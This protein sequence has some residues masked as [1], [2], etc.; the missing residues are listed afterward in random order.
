MLIAFTLSLSL[1]SARGPAPGVARDAPVRS[2]RDTAARTGADTT[3]YVT[4]RAR[5]D[6]RLDR[7]FADSLEYGFIVTRYREAAD[8]SRAQRLLGRFSSERGDSVR[9][10]RAEFLQRVQSG[11]SVAAVHGEGVVLYIHGFATSFRRAV[12]QGT[13][14]AHRTQ[15]SG[16]MVIF[17]WPANRAPTAWPSLHALLS[18]AYRQDSA[19]A[20]R[21]A[22]ALVATIADLRNVT[23]PRSLTVVG[24]SLGAL[25]VTEA[26][27]MTSALRDSLTVSPLRALVLFAPDLSATRF[28]DSLAAPLESVAARRVVYVSQ[29]DRMLALSRL[30]NHSTR[31]GQAG[32]E[33]ALAAANV[34]V[35]DV[36]NGLRVDNFMLRLVEPHHAMRWASSALYDFIGVVKGAPSH[37]RATEGIATLAGERAWR[38]TSA[39]IPVLRPS[40]AAAAVVDEPRPPADA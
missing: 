31:A 30:V 39:A 28:R 32:A 18:R 17:S 21:S 8:T 33:T 13:E 6:G 25:L 36:T 20:L 9:L 3:F 38:L 24:H 34:E 19:F 40:C 14:I 4:N 35:V 26:L 37:C 15:L 1:L 11:D 27:R 7:Q 10:T 29:S 5:R 16:P 22:D 23:R 12:A 2:P